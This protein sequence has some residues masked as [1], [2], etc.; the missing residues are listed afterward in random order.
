MSIYGKC[1]SMICDIWQHIQTT[2]KNLNRTKNEHVE[3]DEQWHEPIRC[4]SVDIEV[5]HL[6]NCIKRLPTLFMVF[7]ECAMFEYDSNVVDDDDDE[8]KH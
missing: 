6:R 2:I 7:W 1:V 4:W 5:E 3:E 8:T